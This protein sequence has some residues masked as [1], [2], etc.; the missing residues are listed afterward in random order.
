MR[1][2]SCSLVAAVFL[3]FI[4]SP[5]YSYCQSTST[6]ETRVNRIEDRKKFAKSYEK[7]LLKK[8]ADVYVTTLGKDSTTLHISHILMNRPRVYNFSNNPSSMATLKSLGF[9]KVIMTD[10][11][12]KTW[13]FK[14]E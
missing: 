1:K 10:G 7:E 9:K 4:F 6:S 5:Q 12:D 3:L 11:Y 2:F 14:V 13:S 8:G